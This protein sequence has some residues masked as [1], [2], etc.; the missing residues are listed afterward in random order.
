ML[1][2]LYFIALSETF[3]L[4]S[5]DKKGLCQ[6]FCDLYTNIFDDYHKQLLGTLSQNNFRE[7]ILYSGNDLLYK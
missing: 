5:L 6:N 1:P 2:F 3:A 7:H 4:L